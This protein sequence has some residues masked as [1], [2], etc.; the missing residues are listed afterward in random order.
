M[1]EHLWIHYAR[2]RPRWYEAAASDRN[3]LES[4]WV[5]VA[6]A[7]QSRGASL[8]G[9]WNV[10]G[11]SDFSTAEVWTFRDVNDVLTHWNSLV[12]AGYPE[13]F[14]TTNTLGSPLPT[15]P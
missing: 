1:T 6:A 3:V 11:Q 9:R 7:S 2:P 5:E 14:A 15:S 4:A 8:V 13:W 12:A 10:R